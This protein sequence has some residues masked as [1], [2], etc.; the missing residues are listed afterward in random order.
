MNALIST[1]YQCE[2]NRHALIIG[3]LRP[4]SLTA[5]GEDLARKRTVRRSRNLFAL[6]YNGAPSAAFLSASS[7]LFNMPLLTPIQCHMAPPSD[8][9]E[10]PLQCKVSRRECSLS[11]SFSQCLEMLSS[12]YASSPC[13]SF[14]M[15]QLKLSD[16]AQHAASPLFS[17]SQSIDIF[18]VITIIVVLVIDFPRT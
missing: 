18:L 8:N 3:Q 2:M 10:A 7:E 16:E 6:L 5:A 1:R 9:A 17:R 15:S 4:H 12:S 14:A 13:S 11:S